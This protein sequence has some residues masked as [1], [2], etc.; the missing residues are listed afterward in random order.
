VRRDELARRLA[1]WLVA[2]ACQDIA[3]GIV[4]ADAWANAVSLG[5]GSDS[6]TEFAHIGD[7]ARLVDIQSTGA[8]HIDPLR[9]KLA[10]GV[11]YLD[12]VILP[13]GDVDLASRPYRCGSRHTSQYA[14][15]REVDH[16]LFKKL[17]LV[18]EPMGRTGALALRA[19]H[20]SR[21][22]AGGEHG[23]SAGVERKPLECAAE[24][25]ARC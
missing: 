17:P 14:L 20:G 22:E 7:I 6:H 1:F 16:L 10:I 23:N 13:V 12:A 2:Q 15:R 25:R 8:R 19:A 18:R 21:I 9:F 3:F 11:K 4:E 24:A 5:I